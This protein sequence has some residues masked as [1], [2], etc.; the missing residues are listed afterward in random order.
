[1][2]C[3]V[4]GKDGHNK[5]SCNGKV[6]VFKKSKEPV[7]ALL[8]SV[9]SNDKALEQSGVGEAVE[10]VEEVEE[11]VKP[12]MS[13]LKVPLPQGLEG[14]VLLPIWLSEDEKREAL[15]AIAK[16]LAGPMV[17]RMTDPEESSLRIAMTALGYEMKVSVAMG[18]TTF[19][20]YGNDGR[21]LGAG[22]SRKDAMEDL[23]GK[24][25]PSKFARESFKRSIWKM[26]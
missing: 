22:K 21:W 14:L 9:V 6:P 1:M 25:L 12:E 10:P 26:A 2:S 20:V 24:M 8:P 13:E 11:E 3:S 18:S 16:E 4:C 5:R 7:E 17:A 19:A 15:S 23:L